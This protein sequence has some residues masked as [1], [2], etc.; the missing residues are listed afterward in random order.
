MNDNVI[1][2]QGDEGQSQVVQ[3]HQRPIDCDSSTSGSSRSTNSPH[4]M[5]ILGLPPFVPGTPYDAAAQLVALLQSLQ[6]ADELV[7][8]GKGGVKVHKYTF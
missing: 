7:S 5:V 6:S 8:Q 2:Q 3:E 1:G 4:S